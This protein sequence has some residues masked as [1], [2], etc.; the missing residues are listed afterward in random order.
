MLRNL[1]TIILFTLGL[2][3]VTPV[4]GVSLGGIRISS[5][6][7][8][9]LNAEIELHDT[10]G[11]SESEVFSSIAAINDFERVGVSRANILSDLRFETR[12]RK[13]D[14]SL[15][16]HV[17]SF[18][19]ISEP[20][21]NF[22]V[23]VHWPQGRLLREYTLIL[24]PEAVPFKRFSQ[25]KLSP[26]YKSRE[27]DY[28]ASQK[29]EGKNVP[30]PDV[31]TIQ[32]DTDIVHVVE[33][34]QTLWD[35]AFLYM[36]ASGKNQNDLMSMIK[37]FN[38][39]SFSEDGSN[40]LTQGEILTIPSIVSKA[41]Y[42]EDESKSGDKLKPQDSINTP[43][44]GGG[45]VTVLSKNDSIISKESSVTDEHMK[46]LLRENSELKEKMLLLET[47]FATIATLVDEKDNEI[48]ILTELTKSNISSIDI[49]KEKVL[50]VLPENISYENDN[51]QDV[52]EH[53]NH[54]V[55]YNYNDTPKKTDVVTRHIDQAQEKNINHDVAEEDVSLVDNF[56]EHIMLIVAIVLGML[57]LLALF[58]RRKGES[59][60]DDSYMLFSEAEKAYQQGEI[61]SASHVQEQLVLN[62]NV[63]NKLKDSIP[64]DSRMEE[65]ELFASYGRYKQASEI[66][67]ELLRENP[68]KTEYRFVLLDFFSQMNNIMGF[69]IQLSIIG[70]IDKAKTKEEVEIYKSRFFDVTDDEFD[71][72]SIEEFI[73]G[74]SPEV[75]KLAVPIS[76]AKNAVLNDISDKKISDKEIEATEINTPSM[77]GKDELLDNVD[78]VTLED[79]KNQELNSKASESS[80]GGLEELDKLDSELSLG[81]F[82][83]EFTSFESDVMSFDDVDI[84]TAENQNKNNNLAVS[85]SETNDNKEALL[86]KSSLNEK[87]EDSDGIDF[88][89]LDLDLSSSDVVE[90][91]V[92]SDQDTLNDLSESVDGIDFEG[93]DLEDD[94]SLD[95]GGTDKS[96]DQDVLE[97]DVDLSKASDDI[98]SIDFEGLDLEDDLSLDEDGAGKSVDEDALETDAD[99]NKASDDIDSIDFEGLD[100]EDDLSFD[101]DGTD[102]SVDESALEADLDLNKA[103]DDIDSID[104][105]G[106]DLDDD[107]SSDEDSADEADDENVLD[108]DGELNEIPEHIDGIDFEGLDLED[109]LSSDE[110]SA[111]KADDENVLDVDGEL[112]EIPEHIDGIDFEG[113]DLEDDLS[114]DEDGTD[115]SVDES[116]LEADSDLNKASDDIDSID[117]EGLDLED[118]LLSDEDSAD[119]A[120]D[121]NVLDVDGELNEIPEHI[122]GINIEGLDLEDDF[123]LDED[124]TDES[125]DES[126]LEDDVDLNKASDDIDS[127]DFEGL[128]LED[129]LSFDEDSADKADD[130][131]VLDVDGELN[132]V[133]EQHIDG[134]DVEGLDLENDLSFD[135]DS[136]DKSVDENVLEVEVDL[137]EISKNIDDVDFEGLDVEDDLSSG[138]EEVVDVE[139]GA[140]SEDVLELVASGSIADI[141][142]DDVFND[143]VIESVT[144]ELKD[145]DLGNV[146]Y[147]E[148]DLDDDARAFADEELPT[149][150]D[151]GGVAT[152]LDLAIAYIEMGD[153]DDAKELL[154]KVV[155]DGNEEEVAEA[156]GLMGKFSS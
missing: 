147:E 75:L 46:L 140:L 145:Q 28:L 99:L 98:D 126:V 103:S 70:N 151:D 111:D 21:L 40:Y 6:L 109:D 139:T 43:V 58:I 14:G 110:N 27:F 141:K 122:D 136:D 153:K 100:L 101:E 149:D 104:F 82:E 118:D 121:E 60:E 20:V 113:L 55:D 4:L 128:N 84:G 24:S 90:K 69:K 83:D 25:A 116:V 17:Y 3:Y 138:D 8:E 39:E 9:A 150:I 19:I 7:N 129:D 117:F 18:K 64:S 2:H 120:D 47:R 106:L 32:R 124:G 134:I 12:E 89:D 125:V 62:N 5:S 81:D 132:E 44:N 73:K 13:Q 107:L 52:N 115:E 61:V 119:K 23:E 1:L 85:T 130:E 41:S 66:V 102:E 135:E 22:L 123:S 86:S 95:E 131:N 142:N 112:N 137:D 146:D 30:L 92:I 156:K 91:N 15:V 97:A 42:S 93:L 16:I 33:E 26:T 76:T 29:Q 133:P 38:P 77:N 87:S 34:G 96:V 65:A 35:I 53:L 148:F 56:A 80:L 79:N 49:D 108:V 94:L 68:L 63:S 152:M 155:R 144:E 54:D 10:K 154:N 71:N 51:R 48:N 57:F 67:F 50:P 143:V 37:S 36:D 11:L 74:V 105:E 59:G 127:I 31:V 88:D 72:N 45:K 114:L 78:N